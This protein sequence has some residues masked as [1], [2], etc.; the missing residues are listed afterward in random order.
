VRESA[1]EAGE[2]GEAVAGVAGLM[3]LMNNLENSQVADEKIKN[4]SSYKMMISNLFSHPTFPLSV[5]KVPFY[6]DEPK[7]FQYVAE[8]FG[9]GFSDQ[10]VCGYGSDFVKEKAAHKAIYEAIERACLIC[11]DEIQVI[12]WSI[13]AMPFPHCDIQKLQSFTKDQLNSKSFRRMRYSEEDQFSW[14]KAFN[15]LTG[16]EAWLPAQFV[17]CPYDVSSEPLVRFPSSN[18][19]AL[20]NTINE[21]RCKAVLEVIERDAYMCWYLAA[22]PAS[23]IDSELAWEN[24]SLR[25][26]QVIYQRYKL[27]L[28]ILVLPS[29]WEFPVVL[30]IIIDR[31]GIGPGI[32]LGMKCHPH[33]PTAISGAVAEAQQ[34]RPWLRDYIQVYGLPESL[35]QTDIVDAWSR[36][37]FWAKPGQYR[38]LE[39]LWNSASLI[40]LEE[41]RNHVCAEEPID[42]D[43]L[44]DK[45]LAVIKDSQTGLFLVDLSSHI[46]KEFGVSVYKALIP[47][48][49][50]IYMDDRF[51]YLN[52]RNLQDVLNL[53][54]ARWLPTVEDDPS[55]IIP[56]HPFS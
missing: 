50:P 52:S 25:R 4:V 8:L 22:I 16:E 5:K 30:A 33:L 40:S 18:G 27:D 37:V 55:F 39:T 36:A 49:H 7:V 19:T 17:F 54:G 29:R 21:A 10:P 32:T 28:K 56:P 45:L 34:M 14:T 48:A 2:A 35:K 3:G 44:W 6:N 41:Y 23:L 26:I 38:N 47:D 24:E 31:T 43:E 20:G 1:G 15:A 42:W 11:S 46:G 13:A 53:F 51:P 9:P 12:Q